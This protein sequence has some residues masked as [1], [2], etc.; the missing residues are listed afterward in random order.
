[1]AAFRQLP[2]KKP[3]VLLHEGLA[4]RRW[5]SG[6]DLRDALDNEYELAHAAE[7]TRG[8]TGP[9]TGSK[10]SALNAEGD[11]LRQ[12]GIDRDARDVAEC[13]ISPR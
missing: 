9:P 13:A 6:S 2:N 8:G 10:T 12:L 11:H 4:R 7:R 3:L 1:M 5:S